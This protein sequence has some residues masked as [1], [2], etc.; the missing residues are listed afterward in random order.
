LDNA[1]VCWLWIML[2]SQAIKIR[3]LA[4]LRMAKSKQ[5]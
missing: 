1:T 4:T 2:A 3:A 5:K